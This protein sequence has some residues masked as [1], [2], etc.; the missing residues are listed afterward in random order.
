MDEGDDVVSAEEVTD[1]IIGNNELFAVK[2]LGQI[3]YA[4]EEITDALKALQSSDNEEL[5]Q[6]MEETIHRIERVREES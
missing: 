4:Y 2:W 3:V 6:A 5:R 1:E